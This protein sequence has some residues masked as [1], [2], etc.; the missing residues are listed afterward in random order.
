MREFCPRKQGFA[1]GLR[2]DL[3]IL[4]KGAMTSLSLFKPFSR[5]QC[6]ILLSVS[7]TGLLLSICLSVCL[8]RC[9]K[10]KIEEIGEKTRRR[11]EWWEKRV[12]GIAVCEF[13]SLVLGPMGEDRVQERDVGKG[14]VWKQKTQRER[15]RER[16]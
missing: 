11:G 16:V 6:R 9:P 12:M 4:N 8:S 7:P 14:I 3:L 1:R 10:S 15:E 13:Q 5:V 2:P